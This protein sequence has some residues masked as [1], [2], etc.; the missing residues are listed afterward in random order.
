MEKLIEA[1]QKDMELAKDEEKLSDEEL[2]KVAG[3]SKGWGLAA[4]IGGT[5][6]IVGGIGL[7]FGAALVFSNPI[8]ATAAI[9]G[10]A[11]LM[12]GGIATASKGG[13]ELDDIERREELR[14]SK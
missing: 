6:G 10:G 7:F 4:V 2:D 14:K 8:T 1:M 5:G 9:V 13:E 11:A 12:A 3:G